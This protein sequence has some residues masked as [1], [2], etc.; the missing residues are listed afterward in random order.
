MSAHEQA[1]AHLGI[2]NRI[3]LTSNSNIFQIPIELF[4]KPSISIKIPSKDLAR[5]NIQQY[6]ACC[7]NNTCSS[8]YKN[9]AA[10]QNDLVCHHLEKPRNNSLN[11]EQ[12]LKSIFQQFSLFLHCHKNLIIFL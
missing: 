5:P 8:N 2:K 4:T 10:L 1:R 11:W 7:K 9:E 6:N 3:L 12:C